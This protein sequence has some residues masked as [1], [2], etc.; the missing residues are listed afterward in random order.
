MISDLYYKVVQVDMCIMLSDMERNTRMKRD[1]SRGCRPLASLGT[2][3][4]EP[5]RH[6]SFTM[7]NNS[8]PPSGVALL[9]PLFNNPRQHCRISF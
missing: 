3:L 4:R 9:I 7:S 5:R 6:S 2:A 1:L 8:S